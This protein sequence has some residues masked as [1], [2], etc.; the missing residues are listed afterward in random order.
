MAR[1]SSIRASGHSRKAQFSTFAGYIVAT[2]GALLGASLLIF[3]LVRPEAFADVRAGAGDIAAPAG[4]AGAAARVGSQDIFTEI[5]GYFRAGSQ[6]ARL[7]REVEVARVRLAEAEALEQENERLKRLLRLTEGEVKPVATGRLI[8]STSASARRFAYVSAGSAD[9]VRPGMP[10]VSPLGLIGRVL[11][12]GRT[13]SR[14]LLLSD[15]ESMVPVR[16]A[17]DNVIAFAEGRSDG[18]VRLRLVNLGIN[19]LKKG[20][21]F[22]TSGAGGL[23][24]PGI[25]VAVADEITRDGAIARLLSNPA[26]TDY[27]MIEPMWQPQA[28][29]VAA[30]VPMSEA[31]AMTESAQAAARP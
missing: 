1:P 18:T 2:L 15:G 26:A 20:D 6:N 19:P 16:R 11:E 13:S 17:K 10:V 5:G 8:G 27:V 14:V 9:G 3:S 30:G 23:Y 4:Q 31:E 28:R 25:A 7:R 29:A 12:T 22:V 24:R 21:V